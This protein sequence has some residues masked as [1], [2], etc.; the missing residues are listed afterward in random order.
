MSRKIWNVMYVAGNPA[1]YSQV[2]ACE[3]NPLT[4]PQ[5]MEIF[6]AI[7]AN[8]WRVYIEHAHTGKRMAESELEKTWK[9]QVASDGEK[10]KEN[11]PSFLKDWY[12]AIEQM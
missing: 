6:N 1:I 12:E 11:K 7:S 3:E 9:N 8:G 5:A 2:R 4:R 10:K